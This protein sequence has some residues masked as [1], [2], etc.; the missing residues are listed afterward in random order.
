MFS[1]IFIVLLVWLSTTSSL[2]EAILTVSTPTK[3]GL[4]FIFGKP[5]IKSSGVGLIDDVGTERVLTV[6]VLVRGDIK[7]VVEEEIDVE[8]SVSIEVDSGVT[9]VEKN[10]VSVDVVVVVDEVDSVVVVVTVTVVVVVVLVV[11]VVVVFV[12]V[13]VAIWEVEDNGVVDVG[14]FISFPLKL[15]SEDWSPTIFRNIDTSSS[16]FGISFDSFKTSIYISDSLLSSF[17]LF[18]VICLF[19]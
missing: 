1:D 5:A 9:E 6:A 18:L 14:A 13:M 10:A 19:C 12:V 2:L 3:I 7:M 17:S 8:T 11:V 16:G 4:C 15:K